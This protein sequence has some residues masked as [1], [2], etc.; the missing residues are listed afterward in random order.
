MTSSSSSSS[1][2]SSSKSSKRNSGKF[3][4]NSAVSSADDE[5]DDDRDDFSLVDLHLQSARPVVDS[6]ILLTSYI[7]HLGGA[8]CPDWSQQAPQFPFDI[9]HSVVT[10]W[11][12]SSSFKPRFVMVKSGFSSFRLVD[13]PSSTPAAGQPG[14]G[15]GFFCPNFSAGDA[16]KLGMGVI[17]LYSFSSQN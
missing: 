3:S 8:E 15:Y 7:T 14:A 6:P 12:A 9:R 1:H 11:P 13:R 5:D 2:S 4:F 10:A 16:D 17:Y